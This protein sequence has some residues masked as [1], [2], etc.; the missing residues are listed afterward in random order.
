MSKRYHRKSFSKTEPLVQ[1]GEVDQEFWE[2]QATIV[3]I[4]DQVIE[5]FIARNPGCKREDLELLKAQGYGYS[6]TRDSFIEFEVHFE[7]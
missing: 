5:S 4:D 1:I 2:A 7:G 6:P 3:P